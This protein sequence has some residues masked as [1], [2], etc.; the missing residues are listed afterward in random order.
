MCAII[1][2]A[3]TESDSVALMCALFQRKSIK[4]NLVAGLTDLNPSIKKSVAL[5]KKVSDD[6]PFNHDL[7][8]RKLV[9]VSQGWANS[10]DRLTNAV[11]I[12]L[13]HTINLGHRIPDPSMTAALRFLSGMRHFVPTMELF[14]KTYWNKQF[15]NYILN[16]L[17]E[18]RESFP[19]L[20]DLFVTQGWITLDSL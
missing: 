2:K 4:C 14:W 17:R 20:V 16:A 3:G 5:P 18:S 19:K 7:S 11:L 6:I 12:G 8:A 1:S 15:P 10:S 13:I 9:S